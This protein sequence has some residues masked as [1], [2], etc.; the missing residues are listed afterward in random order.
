[1]RE[2]ASADDLSTVMSMHALPLVPYHQRK[3]EES[4][5]MLRQLLA[6]MLGKNHRDALAI[7]SNLA[8]VLSD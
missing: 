6:M 3:F 2:I 5:V 8:L 7:M 1:M 4:E